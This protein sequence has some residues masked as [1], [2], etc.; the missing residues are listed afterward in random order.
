MK[1]LPIEITHNFV[2][3]NHCRVFGHSLKDKDLLKNYII[4]TQIVY[5]VFHSHI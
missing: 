4:F 2:N 5:F 1:I 3:C